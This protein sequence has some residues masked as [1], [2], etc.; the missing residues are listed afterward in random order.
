MNA[1]TTD[2]SRPSPAVAVG[3]ASIAGAMVLLAAPAVYAT[4]SP[5]EQFVYDFT[6]PKNGQSVVVDITLGSPLTSN[7]N[8]WSI[9]TLTVTSTKFFCGPCLTLKPELPGA[10]EFNPNTDGLLGSVMGTY[11]KGNSTHEFELVTTDL[12]GGTWTFTNVGNSKTSN[13]TYALATSTTTGVPEPATL[14]LLGLGLAGIGLVR[15]RLPR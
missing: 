8:L 9:A 12:P 11:K 15:R 14:G 6:E 3:W 1:S 13:G 2:A 5:G 4:D 10:L 7:P